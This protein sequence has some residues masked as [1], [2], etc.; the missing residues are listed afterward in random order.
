MR[1]EGEPVEEVGSKEGQRKQHTGHFIDAGDG[2]GLNVKL[3]GSHATSFA[4]L[5][6][7]LLPPLV[8]AALTALLLSLLPFLKWE[9][10]VMLII[11]H[12]P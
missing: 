2:V 9:G 12:P 4:S 3:L 11:L 5:P 10:T 6:F 1:E 8:Q 7:S